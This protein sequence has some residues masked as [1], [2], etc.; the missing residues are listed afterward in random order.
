M[1]KFTKTINPNNEF[2]ISNVEISTNDDPI[3]IS[4]L[5]ELMDDFLKAC[6]FH[7]DGHLEIVEDD[8]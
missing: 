8:E 5:L 3:T 6:G 1:Y 4:E 7:Y 2:D